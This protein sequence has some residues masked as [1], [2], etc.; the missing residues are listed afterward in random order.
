MCVVWVEVIRD[1]TGLCSSRGG[2][3]EKA[4]VGGEGLETK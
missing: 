2:L 4:V 3:D 1:R